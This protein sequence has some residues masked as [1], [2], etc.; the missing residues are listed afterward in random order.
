M[1]FKD[2]KKRVRVT[3]EAEQRH[4]LFDRLKHR[5]FR[6]WDL[7]VH[8]LQ[9]ITTKGDCCFNHILGLPKKNGKEFPMFDYQ[10]I[11]YDALLLSNRKMTSRNLAQWGAGNL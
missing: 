2:L 8:K 1:T 4:S 6:I 7:E 3:Q 10:K 11:I 9:D 5:P